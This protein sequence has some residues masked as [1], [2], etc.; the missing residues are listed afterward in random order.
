MHAVPAL[1]FLPP[2]CEI[3]PTASYNFIN[4]LVNY[5]E[6]NNKSSSKKINCDEM[7][8]LHTT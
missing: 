1:A 8:S 4:L 3:F 5:T 7:F 2:L 6:N